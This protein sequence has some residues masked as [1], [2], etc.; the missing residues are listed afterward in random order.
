[1]CVYGIYA[2]YKPS[3]KLVFWAVWSGG[4]A[5]QSQLACVIILPFAV[6]VILFFSPLISN[7]TTAAAKERSVNEKRIVIECAWERD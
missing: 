5:W 3:R 7:S 4:G 2:N 1:M 6:A